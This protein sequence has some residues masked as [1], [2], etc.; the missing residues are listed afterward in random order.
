MCLRLYGEYGRAFRPCKPPGPAA[1]NLLLVM[2][3]AV[4]CR[5]SGWCSRCVQEEGHLCL[6]E[7][8][9]M[10]RP[11]PLFIPP[12]MASLSGPGP[13]KGI[14]RVAGQGLVKK[15]EKKNPMGRQDLFGYHA[16]DRLLWNRMHSHILCFQAPEARMRVSSWSWPTWVRCCVVNLLV[17]ASCHEAGP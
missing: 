14:S 4:T 6:L 16:A 2:T 17:L 7:V 12:S 8:T 10:E 5:S 1:R 15:K 13:F 3:L 9:I 11:V